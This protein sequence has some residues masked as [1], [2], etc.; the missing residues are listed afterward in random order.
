MAGAEP[1]AKTPAIPAFLIRE[2]RSMGF[3]P[4]V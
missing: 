1:A 3:T 4:E 2:R